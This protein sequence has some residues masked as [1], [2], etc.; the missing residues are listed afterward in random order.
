M[1][2]Q[3]MRATTNFNSFDPNNFDPMLAGKFNNATGDGADAGSS[4]ASARPGQKMQVN[5]SLINNAAV[6]LTFELFSFLDS[7]TRRL[8]QEYQTGNYLY[9][10]LT[11]REG[12]LAT[13][14]P[15]ATGKTVG[16]NQ[17]GTLEIRGDDTVPN[18][19][20]TIGCGEIAYASFF[21]ASGI[22]PFSVTGIR[23]T[24]T[25]D[26]QIDNNIV[27]FSKSYS[28]GEKQNPISPRSFFRP[29]QF[30]PLTL[31]LTVAFDIGIDTGLRVKLL[32]SEQVKFALFI[33]MWT[34]Q[35]LI[36]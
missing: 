4:V 31:D 13:A 24:V 36:N 16:F 34:N 32:A 5:L 15:G 17:L 23:Y 33:N 26:N 28:G 19:I 30:Q 12:I 11:S 10:P 35:T 3:G 29:N 20:G 2:R 14:G 25:T 1:G 9:I 21:E 22:T 8:K 18:P 27:Y 7:Y 6:E